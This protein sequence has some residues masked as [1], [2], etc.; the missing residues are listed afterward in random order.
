MGARNPELL[1]GDGAYQRLCD[2]LTEPVFVLDVSQQEAIR[3]VAANAACDSFFGAPGSNA[4]TNLWQRACRHRPRGDS[5]LNASVAKLPGAQ[6]SF[7]SG[8]TRAI[9]R[10]SG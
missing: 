9:G 8:C 10:C 1:V 2:A 5:P 3:I 7:G 4:S 6:S